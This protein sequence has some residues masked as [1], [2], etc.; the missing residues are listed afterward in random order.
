M[1]CVRECAAIIN[2]YNFPYVLDTVVIY[3]TLVCYSLSCLSG[4]MS[5]CNMALYAPSP[6]LPLLTPPLPLSL[7]V[8][9][10]PFL[11]CP[12]TLLLPVAYGGTSQDGT[13]AG[14]IVGDG[15][16]GSRRDVTDGNDTDERAYT[17]AED[18]EE[19]GDHTP[20]PS[21]S[22]EHS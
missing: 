1:G 15:G 5:G 8:P 21:Q 22:S 20:S 3:K 19:D 2:F 12:L 6:P 4:Y 13:H 18:Q 16:T 7:P 17:S 11:T 14:G 10:L 9:S